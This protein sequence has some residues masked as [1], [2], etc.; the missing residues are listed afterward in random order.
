MILIGEFT[1]FY[2]EDSHFYV[3]CEK[4]KILAYLSYWVHSGYTFIPCRYF[5]MEYTHFVIPSYRGI[6]KNQK[7]ITITEGD[8]D[9]C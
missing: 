7:L 3:I 6:I 1:D 5:S 8:F 9:Y 2:E 4:G